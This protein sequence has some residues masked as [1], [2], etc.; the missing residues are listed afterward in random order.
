ML[1][2]AAAVKC[3]LR[4]PG[5]LLFSK[6]GMGEYRQIDKDLLTLSMTFSELLF[7]RLRAGAA[8]QQFSC[9]Q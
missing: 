3:L 4:C 8:S 2:L 1:A 6:A 7:L 9:A 5:C